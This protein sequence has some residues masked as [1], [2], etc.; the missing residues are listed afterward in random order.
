MVVEL[1]DQ[2]E[3][4]KVVRSVWLKAVTKV[5]LLAGVKVD[6]LVEMKAVV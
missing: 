6:A 5:V 3:N 2:L 4:W 1:A